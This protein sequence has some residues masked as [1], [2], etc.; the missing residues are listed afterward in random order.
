MI[1]LKSYDLKKLN[2]MKKILRNEKQFLQEMKPQCRLRILPR[3]MDKFCHL[4]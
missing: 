3:S 1:N 2:H 4:H